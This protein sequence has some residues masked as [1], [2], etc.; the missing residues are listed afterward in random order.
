MPFFI[1]AADV[2][3]NLSWTELCNAL[4]EGHKAPRA[5][6]DDILFKRRDNASVLSGVSFETDL[7]PWISNA[8]NSL[9]PFLVIL[10]SFVFPP[11]LN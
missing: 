2:K 5:D 7:A 1:N 11:E 10:S 3:H 9:L 4:C 8:L 6:I